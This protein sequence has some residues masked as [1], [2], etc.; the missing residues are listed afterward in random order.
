M[1]VGSQTLIYNLKN[2]NQQ[3]IIQLYELYYLFEKQGKSILPF[4][5]PTTSSSWN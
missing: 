2:W 3:G 5:L 1:W 4:Y